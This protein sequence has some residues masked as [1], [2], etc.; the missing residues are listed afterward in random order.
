MHARTH[1]RAR[2]F[3]YNA[4]LYTH[5]QSHLHTYTHCVAAYV[6]ICVRGVGRV[7]SVSPRL[8]ARDRTA[9]EKKKD[10]V[11]AF[12]PPALSLP[13]FR[14]F[15][16][17]R[18]YRCAEGAPGGR[19][20]VLHPTMKWWRGG[21]AHGRSAAGAETRGDSGELRPLQLRV[22]VREV[23]EGRSGEEVRRGQGNGERERERGSQRGEKGER[24]IPISPR[25]Y[26]ARQCA[27]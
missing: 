21:G 24:G 14:A 27:P 25:G 1:A 5:P 6:L 18:S 20:A 22:L 15:S 19:R 13:L 2:A 26:P 8:E 7:V 23:V 9:W 12:L 11:L 3:I 16:F 4:H 17:V 10:A